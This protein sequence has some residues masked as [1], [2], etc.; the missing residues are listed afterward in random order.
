MNM[1]F[2][3]YDVV[4]AICPLSSV[5]SAG[6]KGTVLMLFPGKEPHYEVEFMSNSGESLAVLTVNEPN[7]K[8]YAT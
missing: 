7:L 3:E 4:E 8:K 1:K 6:T 5:V 2:S